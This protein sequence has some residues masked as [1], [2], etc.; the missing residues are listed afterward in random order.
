MSCL[1]DTTVYN[2]RGEN[3]YFT[4]LKRK[5]GIDLIINVSVYIR[6]IRYF[7][8]LNVVPCHTLVKHIQLF[9][10]F[11]FI[12]IIQ[13]A[14]IRNINYTHAKYKY[15]LVFGWPPVAQLKVF[16]SSVSREPFFL[17]HHSV[18]I[19]LDCFSV[20]IHCIS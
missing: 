7:N 10:T 9:L 4:I 12:K 19:Q 8:Y 14:K 15:M 1:F 18:F 20:M 17:F 3:K 11:Q 13:F 2:C 16:F 5:S 6:N